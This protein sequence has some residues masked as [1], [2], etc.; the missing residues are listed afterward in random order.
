M[1]KGNKRAVYFEGKEISREE[2]QEIKNNQIENI[3]EKEETIMSPTMMRTNSNGD[4][5]EVKIEPAM[6]EIENKK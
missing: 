2:I 6:Y 4:I 1:N 3:E 5:E